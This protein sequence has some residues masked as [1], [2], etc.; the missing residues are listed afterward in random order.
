MDEFDYYNLVTR[1]DLRGFDAAEKKAKETANRI[2]ELKAFLPIGV[3]D[4]DLRA[5]IRDVDRARAQ[6]ARAA[7]QADR[8]AAAAMQRGTNAGRNPFS[9]EGFGRTVGSIAAIAAID[10]SL[11]ALSEGMEA[12]NKAIE[13]GENGWTAFA[14]GVAKS[15][16]IFKEVANLGEQV[17]KAFERANTLKIIPDALKGKQFFRGGDVLAEDAKRQAIREAEDAAD[18]I[19]AEADR[20]TE[21]SIRTGFNQQR[22]RVRQEA[23]AREWKLAGIRVSQPGAGDAV[24]TAMAK[25]RVADQAQLDAI[26]EKETERIT[27]IVDDFFGQIEE[28]FRK[29][30]ERVDGDL[31]DFFNAVESGAERDAKRA[32][33][34]RGGAS[35]RDLATSGHPEQAAANRIMRQLASALD[36]AGANTELRAALVEDARSQLRA[37]IPSGSRQ[38]A[39]AISGDANLSSLTR[40]SSDHEVADVLKNLI[41]GKLDESNRLLRNPPSSKTS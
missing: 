2:S 1:A 37:L 26:A 24:D 4:S 14:G 8:R 6:A 28:D 25:G 23:D 3:K 36:E 34:L 22:E 17:G 20:S 21:L 5:V 41:A 32:A 19:G 39:A 18:A 29:K 40:G 16:P 7:D 10:R 30:Q 13:K 33:D 12:Y 38:M 31:E 27:Q 11:H 9:I 15:L 35:E